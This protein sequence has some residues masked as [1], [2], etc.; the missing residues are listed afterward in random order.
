MH[1]FCYHDRFWII[2]ILSQI[3]HDFLHVWI[4]TDLRLTYDYQILRGETENFSVKYSNLLRRVR[5]KDRIYFHFW[6]GHAENIS[7]TLCKLFSILIYENPWCSTFV[8]FIWYYNFTL[9]WSTKKHRHTKR[10]GTQVYIFYCTFSINISTWR[11][12]R[13][14]R[15][16]VNELLSF[17]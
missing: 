6:K 12:R 17:Q 7:T 2:P 11:P 10:N 9:A 8:L 13:Q 1:S 16:K 3:W 4:L 5:P 14:I 15:C